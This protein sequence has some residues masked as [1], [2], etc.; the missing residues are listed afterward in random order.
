MTEIKKGRLVLKTV[1][2]MQGESETIAETYDCEYRRIDGRVCSGWEIVYNETDSGECR[3]AVRISES[4]VEVERSGDYSSLM[5]IEPDVTSPCHVKTP[6]GAMDMQINGKEIACK[7]HENGG[8]AK[9]SYSSGISGTPSMDME[10]EF[11]IE[12]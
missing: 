4:R 10:I 12:V 6:Y 5:V 11:K 3:T 2:K 1:Q 7:L 8:T 9:I